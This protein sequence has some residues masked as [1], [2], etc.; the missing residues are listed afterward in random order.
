MKSSNSVH[1]GLLGVNADSVIDKNSPIPLHYQLEQFLRRG[2]ESGRFQPNQT[3]PTE[4]ELQ[5]Y[6]DLSRTPIR[7]A[8]SKLVAD[9]LVQR[10]RSQGTIVVPQRFDEAL[11]T[12]TSFTEEV[13]SKGQVPRTRLLEFSM[14]PAEQDDYH[15][16][17]LKPGDMIFAIRR[18][19]FINDQPV[20]L[21][22]S[23]LPAPLMPDLRREVFQEEGPYQSMY[24]VLENVC[25]LRPVRAREV[26][27]GVNLSAEEADLLDLPHGTAVLQRSRISFDA[28]DRPIALERGL[29]HVRYQIELTGREGLR[30]EGHQ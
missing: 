29:Y 5:Q 18:L 3:L 11:R 23:R 9:G 30:F 16:L 21:I 17:A 24:Y 14:Q 7:Q 12:L 22:Q 1:P 2:I 20:G 27:A 8:I 28:E 10:R 13:Q 6:F 25:G 26:L 15:N 19:R 4:Y